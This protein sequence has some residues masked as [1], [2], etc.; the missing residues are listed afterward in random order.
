MKRWTVLIAVLFTIIALSCSSGGD[1]VVA[2]S[3]DLGMSD[4]DTQSG[5]T[6]THLWGYYDLYFDFENQSVEA[7]PNHNAMFTANVVQF[8]NGNPANLAFDIHGTPTAP[9]HVDVDIDVSITHPFPG[10]HQYDGYDV[11]GVFMGEG[12]ASLNY[13]SNLDYPSYE[14]DQHMKDYNSDGTDPAY[15]DPY[16]GP[17]GNPDGYTRWFNAS[18]FVAPGVLGYLQGKLATPGYTENLS[19]TLNGYKYF[20]DGLDTE[21]DAWEWLTDGT[22]ADGHGLFSAGA[23]NTR[24]YYLRFPL[25]APGVAYG[26]AILATWGEPTAQ[27]DPADF[28]ENA[29]EAVALSVDLTDDIY[30][31]SDTDWGGDF[32]ADISPFIWEQTPSTILI[33]TSVHSAVESFDPAL[34]VTGGT[35]NYST[36]HVEFTVDDVTEAGYGEYWVILEYDEFDYTCDYPAPAP[37]ATL[38]AFFR[39]DLFIADTPYHTDPD[40]DLQVITEMPHDGDGVIEFDI[41]G[42]TYYDGAVFDHAEW[43]FDGDGTFG[44]TFDEGTEENPIKYYTEDYEG[45]VCVRIYDDMN[46]DVECC[47]A[48]DITYNPLYK[49]TFDSGAG[50]WTGMSYNYLSWC[51]TP[52]TPGYSTNSP[53]GPSG[54]GNFRGPTAGTWSTSYGGSVT[55]AV[56]P[57]FPIPS[58]VSDCWLRIYFCMDNRTSWPDSPEY[59]AVAN[60][61]GVISSA[62]GT[63]PFNGNG[64]LPSGGQVLYRT[65]AHGSTFPAYNAGTSHTTSAGFN[66]QQGYYG[67]YGGGCWPGSLTAYIDLTIP[68]AWYG[69]EIKVAYQMCTDYCGDTNSFGWA[70]DDVELMTQ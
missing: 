19:A 39:Y 67:S 4:S 58:N 41:T 22:N 44:D 20:C 24:N 25:P 16:L 66:G 11:R 52:S 10:V 6:Q 64:S 12:S 29:V 9:D 61:K 27:D 32:I 34:T 2:P 13:G 42:T 50:N 14:L 57:P 26:Y 60:F 15:T 36:Y 59:Y 46:G 68:T 17:V 62:S 70:I 35:D 37:D 45:D 55:S 1:N 40:C 65:T 23:T 53:F 28:V 51:S 48:V 38:A 31:V 8:V 30:Y 3:T 18:E 54:A 7:V 33:E 56:S 63:S 21:T 5:Q 69:E 47:V 49:E 43:D